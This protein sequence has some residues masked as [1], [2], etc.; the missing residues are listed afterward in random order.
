[1][2]NRT[3][4]LTMLALMMLMARHGYAAP[5]SPSSDAALSGV[6]RDAHGVPQMGALV[7]LLTADAT[8]IAT[9]FTD[10]HGR[11]LMST[12]LPGRYQLRATAAFFAPVSRPNIRLQAGAQAIVNL[13]MNT[14]YE[15]QSWLP[16]Q[17][18]RRCAPR[19]TAL[20]CA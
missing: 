5:G 9:A 15:T 2:R 13:T 8:T 12:V 17:K 19:P 20:C 1:M 10:T 18:R 4:L 14:L 7:Q 6:V 3:S 11:Y 16:A